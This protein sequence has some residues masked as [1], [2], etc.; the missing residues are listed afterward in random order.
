M[1]I[2]QHVIDQG[3][4]D[5]ART[6]KGEEPLF[7]L[8][9]TPGKTAPSEL[10]GAHLAKWVR[11]M[12]IDD[13]FVAP[14]HGWRHR[15]ETEAREYKIEERYIDA[16]AGHTPATQGRK[17]GAFPPRVLGPEIAK[18]PQIQLPSERTAA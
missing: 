15:F 6:K 1:P 5:F 3:F 9:S 17:Y 4:L 12:G 8:Q 2:H 10:V 14:N 7:A 13:P 16:I 18:L 11:K